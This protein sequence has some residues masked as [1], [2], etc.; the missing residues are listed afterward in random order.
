MNAHIVLALMF[1]MKKTIVV[2]ALAKKGTTLILTQLM[3]INAFHVQAVIS[4]AYPHMDSLYIF[5][6][7]LFC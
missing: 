5:M 3:D 4:F 2:E 6:C 1:S 7:F